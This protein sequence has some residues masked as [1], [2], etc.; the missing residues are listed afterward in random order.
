MAALAKMHA[1]GMD[2]YTCLPL[3]A[4]FLGHRTIAG[5][6]YYLRLSGPNAA[7]LAADSTAA[8]PGLYP[9][10]VD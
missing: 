4:T 5:T 3:L 10:V 9:K 2:N 8:H 6:E 1:D 7:Q